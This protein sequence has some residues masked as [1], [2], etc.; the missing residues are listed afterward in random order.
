[1]ASTGEDICPRILLVDDDEA[2][3]EGLAV[4]LADAGYSVEPVGTLKAAMDELSQHA[5][6]LLIT[7]VRL[8][9]YNGLQLLAMSPTQV[10]PESS[11]SSAPMTPEEALD[12]VGLGARLDHFPAEM[13]GGEQQRVAIARAIVSDPTLL[14]CDE[15][16]GALDSKTGIRVL[17]ALCRVNDEFG[18]TT[19]VITH[20]AAIRDIAHRVVRFA[21][22]R[23]SSI[24]KNATRKPPSMVSW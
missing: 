12:W 7:D 22:G 18:T 16:T 19:L 24:E 9:G 14:V 23:I 17:E 6:D 4:L 10:T 11:D 13:S 2:T 5:P 3:R 21:D 8:Q 15:P 1:M 20:N